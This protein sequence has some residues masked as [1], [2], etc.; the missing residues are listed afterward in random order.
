MIKRSFIQCDKKINRLFSNTCINVLN[1][2]IIIANVSL[3]INQI[4]AFIFYEW[5]TVYINKYDMTDMIY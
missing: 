3:K 2:C 5:V 1:T 4:I